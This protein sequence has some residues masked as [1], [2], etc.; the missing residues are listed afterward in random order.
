M[1][2]P[3]QSPKPASPHGRWLFALLTALTLLASGCATENWE[4]TNTLW[5]KETFARYYEPASP[6]NLHL[7][8]SKERKDVLVQYDEVRVADGKIQPRYYWLEPNATR[9]SQGQRPHFVSAKESAG[10]VPILITEAP[11][12]SIPS[13]QLYAVTGTNEGLF[14]LYSGKSEGD[15]Y[16][17][18]NY[19]GPSRRVKQVLLTPLAVSADATVLSAVAAYYSLPGLLEGLS[20]STIK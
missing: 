16:E 20:G 14:T 7:F 10:L 6:A 9:I 11:T 1:L 19:I 2:P 13:V 3:D 8:Y 12:N 18:P 5:E 15:P 17:L 4:S